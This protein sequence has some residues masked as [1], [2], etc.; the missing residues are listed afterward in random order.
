[1]EKKALKAVAIIVAVVAAILIGS[2]DSQHEQAEIERTAKELALEKLAEE[3][4]RAN[5]A[6]ARVVFL[7]NQVE[8]LKL[9]IIG[10]KAVLE[11]FR[12]ISQLLEDHRGIFADPGK[13][14]QPGIL[15][16]FLISSD[17]CCWPQWQLE[18][19]R[20]ILRPFL[21]DFES[22]Q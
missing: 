8:G 6:E 15:K 19:V 17:L 1:M 18:S 3:S 9:N 2:L 10:L 12:D 4:S 16:S 14:G 5:V 20:D 11:E 22:I 13:F 7:E 21:R